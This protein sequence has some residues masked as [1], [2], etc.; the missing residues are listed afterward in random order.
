MLEKRET[1][2][3]LQKNRKFLLPYCVP[4]RL[5]IVPIQLRQWQQLPPS[6]L[7]S[8]LGTLSWSG[9]WKPPMKAQSPQ[10]CVNWPL[11]VYSIEVRKAILL[12]TPAFLE[13]KLY[14]WS[15]FPLGEQLNPWRAEIALRLLSEFNPRI[16]NKTQ[17]FS[18]IFTVNCYFQ[19]EFRQATRTVP[20]RENWW[21]FWHQINHV[22]YL[23]S[24][25][26]G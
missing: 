8:T 10:V 20:N 16:K 2:S 22:V 9:H 25:S 21:W 6:S 19:G 14:I 7:W 11:T 15:D 12:L 17:Q 4:K 13:S 23:V 1:D 26:L 24:G 18:L 5:A 3:G